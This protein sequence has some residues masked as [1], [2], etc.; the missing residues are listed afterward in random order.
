MRAL[1]EFRHMGRTD[2]DLR[3]SLD[4]DEQYLHDGKLGMVPTQHRQW[5]YIGQQ[6]LKKAK[7]TRKIKK[8]ED[9][10]SEDED[11]QT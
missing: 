5:G 8:H 6:A 3:P 4:A 9:D 11:D 2:Q 1:T 7:T 10:P